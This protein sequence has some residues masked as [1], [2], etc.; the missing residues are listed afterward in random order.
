MLLKLPFSLIFKSLNNNCF[1]KTIHVLLE[2]YPGQ[3]DRT[4]IRRINTHKETTNDA[5]RSPILWQRAPEP[6][7]M[8]I[9]KKCNC[10]VIELFLK[11]SGN[12]VSDSETKSWI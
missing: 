2:F 6:I 7:P 12:F 1:N 11:G 8:G 3:L 5:K 10:D 9:F 4:T